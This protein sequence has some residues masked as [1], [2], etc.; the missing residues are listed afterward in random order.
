MIDQADRGR[1]P[2]AKEKPKPTRP[3]TLTQIKAI[4]AIA[5]KAVVDVTDEPSR[6]LGIRTPSTND[7]QPSQRDDRSSQK[8]A[9]AGSGVSDRPRIVHP[10][11][12]A[13]VSFPAGTLRSRI[14]CMASIHA[15]N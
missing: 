3:A 11:N 2:P 13:G 6:R 7:H 10:P 12:T 1:R 8:T 4:S 14:D 15:T 5:G 9:H